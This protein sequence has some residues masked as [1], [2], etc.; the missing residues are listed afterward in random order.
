MRRVVEP[1][2]A[3]KT[4]PHPWSHGTTFSLSEVH[5]SLLLPFFCI[6][7]A[8]RFASTFRRYKQK[9]FVLRFHPQLPKQERIDV[10]EFFDLF[11]H[12]L[13]RAVPGFAF[14]SQ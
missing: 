11:G 8:W 5:V 9:N 10:G 6:P 13:S 3:R 7:R 4:Y 12:R 1:L 2:P 14:D